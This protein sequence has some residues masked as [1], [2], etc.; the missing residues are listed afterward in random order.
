M[1]WFTKLFEDREC[2]SQP[3]ATWPQAESTWLFEVPWGIRRLLNWVKEQYND[4]D[5]IITEN[6]FSESGDSNE[7]NDY[8]RKEY[9]V[10]YINEVLKAIQLDDVKV[11][12]YT[13][14][15]LMDNFE[16]AEGYTERFGM[17][18]VDFTSENRERVAKESVECYKEIMRD[19]FPE[20]VDDLE[21]CRRSVTSEPVPGPEIPTP[22][23]T[24]PSG[25]T[26]KSPDVNP[27][28]YVEFL[29]FSLDG[30]SAVTALN[31]LF[32]VTI[33]LTC[34]FIFSSIISGMRMSKLKRHK[35]Y[36]SD[37]SDNIAMTADL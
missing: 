22:S 2:T 4:P 9:Y 30:D 7:L 29:G 31:A 13:A 24:E 20:E 36:R 14:W 15:S 1:V 17:H 11:K 32:G 34:M 23:S 3:D 18:W 12:G 21:Y 27:E 28:A 16:W 5:I 35:K 37:G 26:T 8:W 19:S 10:G 6:G 33:A 25:T